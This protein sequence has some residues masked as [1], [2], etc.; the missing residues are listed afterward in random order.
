MALTTAD[1][2]DLIE[3]IH[4]LC[5]ALDLSRPADFAAVFA[6]GGVYQ[7]VSSIASG[8]QPRFRH[9]GSAELLAFAEAA[10]AKRKGLGRHWTGDVVLTETDAGASAVSYVMFIEINPDTKERRI[11]ISGTHR[12]AFTRTPD[13]W[14]FTSRTVVADI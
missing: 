3:L 5:Q 10:V 4:R 2:L 7:A 13:G 12:D 9:E 1:R 14:R 8:E 6:P 11:A